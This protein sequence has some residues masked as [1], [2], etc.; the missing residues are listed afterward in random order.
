MKRLLSFLFI[1]VLLTACGGASPK[2]PQTEYYTAESI[3]VIAG[4][5]I[6]KWVDRDERAV[7]YITGSGGISSSRN[8]DIDNASRTDTS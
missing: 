8:S 1:F 5:R 4:N 2:D 7:C 3:A 6:Y